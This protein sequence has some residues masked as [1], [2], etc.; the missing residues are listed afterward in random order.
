M[1]RHHFEAE[2]PIPPIF[3]FTL[4]VLGCFLITPLVT[5]DTS[6]VNLI[7]FL[8][9]IA[10]LPPSAR[11]FERISGKH[12]SM[13]TRGIAATVMLFFAYCFDQYD[14]M[15][16]KR[17]TQFLVKK[18]EE[19]PTIKKEQGPKANVRQEE[20]P[21][22]NTSLK[23]SVTVQFRNRPETD[24]IQS[25]TTFNFGVKDYI[26]WLNRNLAQSGIRHGLRFNVS[27]KTPTADG[28]VLHHGLINK[29]LGLMIYESKRG[30]VSSV[31]FIGQGDGSDLSGAEVIL[32]TI[33]VVRAANLT[34][35]VDQETG[36][37]ALDLIKA[38]YE[39]TVQDGVEYYATRD[40]EIGFM[41]TH[42]SR[43]LAKR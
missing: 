42:L 20:E 13:K 12:I 36:R 19:H 18:V 26:F 22:G 39:V 7:L 28:G 14:S 4:W 25:K 40:N 43:L 15:K 33:A 9:G 16:N 3:K 17:Q 30:N 6:Y 29:K 31:I 5:G 8:I 23:K 24:S 11:V 2:D 35:A 1:Q 34:S 37:L 10:L 32:A 38:E 41:L 21:T 27:K